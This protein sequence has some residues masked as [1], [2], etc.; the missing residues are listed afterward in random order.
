MRF[1]NRYFGWMLAALLVVGAAGCAH[2]TG[3]GQT[4]SDTIITSKVK[5]ALLADPDVSGLAVNVETLRGQVQLSGFVDSAQQARRAVDIASR[6]DDVKDV[7][8]KMTV[9]TQN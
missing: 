1:A 4:T 5:T 3:I 9:K 8:N 2:D 6:V 7:I